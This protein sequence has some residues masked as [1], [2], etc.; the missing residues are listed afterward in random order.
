MKILV[1]GHGHLDCVRETRR[2]LAPAFVDQG[3]EIATLQMRDAV[4]HGDPSN[5]AD[6]IG[7]RLR[8]A[9]AEFAFLA[10]AIAQRRLLLRPAA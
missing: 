8:H 6:G 9:I 4:F 5:D 10:G 2:A 3:P 7:D 1:I